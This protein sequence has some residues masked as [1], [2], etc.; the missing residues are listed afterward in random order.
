M[1]GTLSN[2]ESGAT[3]DDQGVVTIESVGTLDVR[4]TVPVE[5]T[6]KLDDGGSFIQRPHRG[7]RK[8][9]AQRFLTPFPDLSFLAISGSY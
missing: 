6:G 8:C 3:L 2:V 4:G 9:F 5:S 1:A 7:K